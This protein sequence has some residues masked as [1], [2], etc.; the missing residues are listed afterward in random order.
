MEPIT[1]MHLFLSAFKD[2]PDTIRLENAIFTGI[3]GGKLA[4]SVFVRHT[5]GNAAD[6]SDRMICETDTGKLHFDRDGTGRA[7][8]VHFH[9]QPHSP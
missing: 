3:A 9:S 5:S 6:A 1:G 8:K 7:A 4:A 2:V